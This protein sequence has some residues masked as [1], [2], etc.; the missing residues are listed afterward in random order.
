VN[1]SINVSG[2]EVYLKRIAIPILESQCIPTDPDLWSI[3]N[4][5]TFWKRR[6]ELLA[7]AFNGFLDA[8]FPNRRLQ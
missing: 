7:E 1:R 2:P 3:E 4:A 6:R 8:A 5:T